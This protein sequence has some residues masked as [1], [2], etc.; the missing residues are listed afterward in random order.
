MN[1]PFKP[2]APLAS[3]TSPAQGTPATPIGTQPSNNVRAEGEAGVSPSSVSP[4]P[5]CKP[6]PALTDELVGR[7]W[8]YVDKR[9]PEDCWP[10]LGGR[11]Y[12]GRGTFS[13]NRIGYRAPR[14][15]WMIAHG[16]DPVL[17][18]CHSCDNP[19]C[20]NPAHLWLGT[21]KDNAQDMVAKGRAG[22]P[23]K[24]HCKRGHRLAGDN[25]YFKP[26]DGSRN[27]RACRRAPI[28]TRRGQ[29]A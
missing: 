3:Q 16:A 2:V 18:V 20:V 13:V 24:S 4:T 29:A 12:S 8:K 1:R 6:L 19:N 11:N 26:S 22:A 21:H 25:L 9:G 10:W 23:L 28:R 5:Y 17:L 15:A 7:Y 27:C 14:I